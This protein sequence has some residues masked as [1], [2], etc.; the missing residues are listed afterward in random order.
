MCMTFWLQFRAQM[1][2]YC[3][4]MLKRSSVPHTS[5]INI[6][7]SKVRP[8]LEYGATMAQRPE[9]RT[10]KCTGGHTDEGMQDCYA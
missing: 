5:I 1:T 8:I 9:P 10:D 2:M 4:R 6:F 3:L 7:C